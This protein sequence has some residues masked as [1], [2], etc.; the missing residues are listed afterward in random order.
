MRWN[1][2]STIHFIFYIIGTTF[3]KI[4][5]N[6]VLLMKLLNTSIL[7]VQEII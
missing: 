7:N 5:L 2:D 3:L 4:V 1:K 6:L